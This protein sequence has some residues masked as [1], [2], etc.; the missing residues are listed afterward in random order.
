MKVLSDVCY[1]NMRHER[2]KLNIYLPESEEFNAFVYFHG[3]GFEMGDR[4]EAEYFANYLAE[5]NIATVSA[6]YRMYPT[7]VYPEFLRDGAAAVAWTFKNIE[8]YGKCKKIYV[9]GTSAGAYLSM[10][11][12]FDKK[13][14]APFKMLPTDIAGYIHNSAQPTTHFNVLRERGIDNRRVIIDEAAPL[15][16]VGME[17]NYSPM[18]IIVSDD[19]IEN[20]H[21]QNNLLMS[22]MKIFGHGDKI[23]FKLMHGK[24]VRYVFENDENEINPF[25]VIVHEYISGLERKDEG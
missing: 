3:G 17:K 23:S 20:R 22:T 9:G 1:S 13:Y 21:E 12:C 6:D 4:K 11:L 2:Q 18:L 15:Y 24:H 8:K 5:R 16:Y 19:D 7:A 14:L 25:G 10:M